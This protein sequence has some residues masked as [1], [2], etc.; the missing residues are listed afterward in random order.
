MQVADSVMC[1]EDNDDNDGIEKHYD[2]GKKKKQQNR[3][4]YCL[5][6]VPKLKPGSEEGETIFKQ[7]QCGC[8]RI[9][10]CL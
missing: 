3:M 5:L 6:S 1:D 8:S 4:K 9:E 2:N 7:L 10:W